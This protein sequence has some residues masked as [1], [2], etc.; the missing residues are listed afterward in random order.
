MGGRSARRG[1]IAASAGAILDVPMRSDVDVSKIE[2]LMAALGQGARGPGRVYLTGGASA[3]LIGWRAATVDVD[4]RLDPEPEGI[5]E[6]IR[7]LKDALDVNVELASPQDFLPELP[8][9][10]ERSPFIARHG[11]VDFFHYDFHAQALAK[12]SRGHGRDRADVRAMVERGLVR[13]ERLADLFEAIGPQLVR[14]P[15]LDAEALAARVAAAVAEL[16]AVAAS[17]SVDDG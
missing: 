5:F 4:L 15:A 11:A 3:L 10:R 6:A 2:R 16:A 17:G 8:G 13:P 7:D 14:F 12:I 9:W 1:L